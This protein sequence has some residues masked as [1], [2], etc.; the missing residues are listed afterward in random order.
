[1][2]GAAF[3]APF[4][5]LLQPKWFVFLHTLSRSCASHHRVKRPCCPLAKCFQ[6]PVEPLPSG[7]YI[8][9]HRSEMG[10]WLKREKGWRPV[11]EKRQADYDLI[12][13]GGGPAGSTAALYAARH[14]LKTLLVDKKRF[15]RDKVCGDGISGKCITI[16][17]EL[18]LLDRLHRS[19]HRWINGV[20]FSSPDGTQFRI[21]TANPNPDDNDHGY[22]CRREVFD[23]LLLDAARQKVEVLEHAPVVDLVHSNGS[24]AGVKIKQAGGSEAE[25]TARVVVGAD[26]FNSVVARK[27]GAYQHDSRHWLV[28]T[29]AY[30]RGVQGLSDVIELHYLRESLPGYFWIFPAEGDLANVG[31]IFLH[32]KMKKKGIRLKEAHLAALQKPLF[33]ERFAG[34]EQLGPIAGWN[35]PVGSI[36]RQVH[37]EGW[38][39][40]GD[41]AGLIDPF[42]GGGIGNAMLSGKIAA[43]TLAELLAE[44]QAPNRQNLGLYSKRVWAAL[45]GELKLGYRLQR[46]ANFGPLINLIVHKAAAHPD[47]ADWIAGMSKGTLPK[48]E[49]V[50]PLT[51][52]RLLFT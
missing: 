12:I 24:V 36:R 52:L 39:L 29:R 7:F 38:V 20:L 17:R 18:N 16:L 40:L 10:R 42:T 45:G 1:M 33:A 25:I 43:Q 23:A 48:S 27:T 3:A 46:L 21:R 50:S 22:V 14:G 35:L 41:A 8:K 19:P 4:L 31:I 6:E 26:G 11:A 47:I 15:P 44:G 9:G 5:F 49:L 32:R 37:G 51:Y 13:V 28:A 30:Y 34:A 2:K